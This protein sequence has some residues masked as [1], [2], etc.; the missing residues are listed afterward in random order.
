LALAQEFDL[1][2]ISSG[3]LQ[4]AENKCQGINAG[5]G[6][7]GTFLTNEK[8]PRK[9]GY[10][11]G[12]GNDLDMPLALGEGETRSAAYALNDAGWVTGSIQMKNDKNLTARVWVPDNDKKAYTPTDLHA[13]L[14]IGNANKSCSEALCLNNLDKPMIVGMGVQVA[15]PLARG[16]LLDMSNK[17]VEWLKP[18]TVIIL[19][20]PG[21]FQNPVPVQYTWNHTLAYR[22]N[23]HGNVCG[24]QFQAFLNGVFDKFGDG[25]NYRDFNAFFYPKGAAT[26]TALLP[27]DKGADQAN[28]LSQANGINDNNFVVGTEQLPLPPRLVRP[29]CWFDTNERPVVLQTKVPGKSQTNGE[30]L[31]IAND[32]TI[33]G[34]TY[35]QKGKSDH[36]AVRW[37]KKDGKNEWEDPED[38][39]AITDLSKFKGYRLAEARS[40]APTGEICGWGVKTI[41]RKDYIFGF[42]LVKKKKFQP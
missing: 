23:K 25:G 27:S 21:P 26:V 4:G 18:A 35:T 33:V 1:I 12:F 28:T 42:K 38:L 9:L 40:I 5:L 7:A 31:A 2:E 8:R 34:G 17:Q 3:N 37:K 15:G 32:G 10:A 14:K 39:N 36:V 30:A 41:D 16:F 6:V 22:V 29:V 19:Q 13:L 11:P 24:W 20:R